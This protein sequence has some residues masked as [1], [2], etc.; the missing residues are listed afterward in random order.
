MPL[1]HALASP[2]V[3]AAALLALGG[4][5]KI[6]RP[7]PAV[8]ALRSVGLPGPVPLVRLLGVVE[9]MIAAG[10]VLSGG[11]VFAVLVAACYLAFAGFVAFALA[12]GGVLSSCGCFGTPDTPPTVLHLVLNLAAACVA[13]GAALT[14]IPGLPAVLAAQPW[15]GLPLL[16][17]T[18]ASVWLAHLALSLLPALSARPAGQGR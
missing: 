15:G 18:A 14:P 8:R 17:A 10:A 7:H 12:R 5:P 4:A 13:V 16:A 1:M 9:V 6:V 2:F 11:P 3:V